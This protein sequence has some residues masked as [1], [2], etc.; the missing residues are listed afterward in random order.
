[1]RVAVRVAVR[2]AEHIG[3]QLTAAEVERVVLSSS[4]SRMQGSARKAEAEDASIQRQGAR[5]S[6]FFRKGVAGDWRAHFSEGLRAE[7]VE[8]RQFQL[9]VPSQRIR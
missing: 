2:V 7:F 8:L 9:T 1:M 5:G 3:V 4:F 6:R